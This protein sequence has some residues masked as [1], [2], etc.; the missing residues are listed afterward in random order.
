MLL[1][2]NRFKPT[3]FILSLTR[4]NNYSH[5]IFTSS[6]IRFQSMMRNTSYD[7]CM[8]INETIIKLR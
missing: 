4:Y 7:L 1:G 2:C 5:D 6:Y 8:T 3:H